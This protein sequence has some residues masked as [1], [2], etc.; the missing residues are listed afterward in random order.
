MASRNDSVIVVGGGIIGIACAHYLAEAGRK[1]TVIDQ[2]DIGKACSHANCGFICPSHVLP[3]TEPGAI[4]EG[5]RSLLNPKAAFRIRPQLRLDLYRW[6]FEFVRRCTHSG[7]ISGGR[8][9]LPL[10]ESSMNEYRRLFAGTG[11]AGEWKENGLLY[12]FHSAPGFEKYAQTDELLSETYGVRARRIEGDELPE[13][14]PAL[15]SGLAGAFFYDDDGSVRPDKLLR[16]WREQLSGTGVVFSENCRV[17]HIRRAGRNIVALETS[18]GEMTADHYVFA[19]G[20]WSARLASE[21]NCRIPVEPGKGYSLTMS[22]PGMQPKHPMLFPEHRIGITPFDDS[23]RIGSMMEFVGFDASIPKQRMTQ[24]RSSAMPYLKT[25]VGDEVLE[26]W[27][28][29][30]PMTWDSLPI[31]GRVPGS[32]NGLLAT[33]HNMLGLT[34]APATGRLIAELLDE[35][36]THIDIEAFS[37]QRF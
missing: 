4:L 32:D 28:G 2:S 9:L 31:V 20:A 22:K 33:G 3:L 6:L 36:P 30:R 26:T 8:K 13:F 29:W 10:L 25:P 27:Y 14:D 12:V 5:M 24:L 16:D 35:S 7:M 34:L 21:L 23:Y 17:E 15:R 37:P 11:L 19:T 1:V 18:Q